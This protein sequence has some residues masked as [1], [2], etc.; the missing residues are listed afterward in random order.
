MSEKIMRKSLLDQL[1][2]LVRELRDTP[3][4]EGNVNRII[5]EGI[6]LAKVFEE[7]TGVS[8]SAPYDLVWSIIH[9]GLK[10]YASNKDIYQVL[11]VLGWEV[12]DED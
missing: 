11:E 12:R 7:E 10:E 4:D 8:W 1:I 9:S 2:A 3:Y 6:A 5:K